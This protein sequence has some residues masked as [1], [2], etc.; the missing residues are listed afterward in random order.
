MRQDRILDHHNLENL[1][2]SI[3]Q[4]MEQHAQFCDGEPV[5]FCEEVSLL[6]YLFMGCHTCNNSE[7]VL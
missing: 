2:H 4:L 6:S 5:F 3:A 1:Y 7:S